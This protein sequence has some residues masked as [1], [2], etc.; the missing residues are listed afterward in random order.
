VHVRAW[1]FRV[2]RVSTWWPRTV[3]T[4]SCAERIADVSSV[5]SFGH[6]SAVIG[7][8]A[9]DISYTPSASDFSSSQ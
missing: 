8:P 5:Y 6:R 7:L 3:V 9:E 2:V 1:M 4:L